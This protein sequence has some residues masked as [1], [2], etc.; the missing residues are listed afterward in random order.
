MTYHSYYEHCGTKWESDWDSACNDVCPVCEESDIEPYDWD[1]IDDET[2][3]G[4]CGA[5][6]YENSE[7]PWHYPDADCRSLHKPT[8]TEDSN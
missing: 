6:L 5:L 3:C 7:F 8:L 1:E 4:S 2:E